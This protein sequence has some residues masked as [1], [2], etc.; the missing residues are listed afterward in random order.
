MI[1]MRTLVEEPADESGGGIGSFK[2]HGHDGSFPLRHKVEELI[3]VLEVGRFAGR[4][5]KIFG[6]F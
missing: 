3:R 2:M 6:Q 5:L 1:S 4:H